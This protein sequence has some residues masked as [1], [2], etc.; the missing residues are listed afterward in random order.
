[1]D[2]ANGEIVF[3]YIGPFVVTSIFEAK[4]SWLYTHSFLKKWLFAVFFSLFLPR[5]TKIVASKNWRL[6]HDVYPSICPK[7]HN[8]AFRGKIG[9]PVSLSN[10]VDLPVL[11]WRWLT[12]PPT[13]PGWGLGVTSCPWNE[14]RGSKTPWEKCCLGMMT[15]WLDDD[16]VFSFLGVVSKCFQVW[17][18]SFWEG[19]YI[20]LWGR[21]ILKKYLEKKHWIGTLGKR[22]FIFSVNKGFSN[23]AKK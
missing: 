4:P 10:K 17:G 23:G 2:V 8:S 7:V 13:I 6:S 21:Y 20:V 3:C 12:D 9:S 1:M 19:R 11:S 16:V 15:W 5:A 18:V 14:G 22:V